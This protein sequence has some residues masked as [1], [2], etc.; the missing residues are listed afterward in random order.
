MGNGINSQRAVMDLEH[1]LK[2]I[3]L[4]SFVELI[5]DIRLGI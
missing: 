4:H 2:Y 5:A 1:H 3:S